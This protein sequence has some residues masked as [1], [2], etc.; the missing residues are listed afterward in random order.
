GAAITSVVDNR[1]PA[2]LGLRGPRVFEFPG[3]TF[4]V[5]PD[6]TKMGAGQMILYRP[7][8]ATVGKTLRRW[9]QTADEVVLAD[10]PLTYIKMDLSGS[11]E[12]DESP[13]GND[14]D[15]GGLATPI[16]G[17]TPAINDGG[18]SRLFNGRLFR[19]VNPLGDL[20][21]S[22]LTLECW[23][24][25]AG[26]AG[27]NTLMDIVD[28]TALQEF[29]VRF[30]SGTLK[31]ATLDVLIGGTTY[32]SG[33]VIKSTFQQAGWMLLHVTWVAAGDI[34]LYANGKLLATI[35]AAAG[36]G[37]SAITADDIIIGL[38]NIGS[39]DELF[40]RIDN[41][42]V[43]T[44]ELNQNAIND[45]LRFGGMVDT[46]WEVVT[47]IETDA[48]VHMTLSAD[49][50]VAT[51]ALT[52]VDLEVIRGQSGGAE[53]DLGPRS[54]STTGDL[55]AD[56]FNNRVVIQKAARYLVEGQVAPDNVSAPTN[57][58]VLSLIRL[59]GTFDLNRGT[60]P[61]TTGTP[62]TTAPLRW[63]GMLD[64]GDFIELFVQS[65]DN[66]YQVLADTAA[67]IFTHLR[68][69]KL[70]DFDIG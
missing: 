68:V 35:S 64:V 30:S 54:K 5:L 39:A 36:G 28:S 47:D 2:G 24:N 62:D 27:P 61:G 16:G 13:N 34:K 45:R 20:S 60:T 21:I 9:A 67:G 40:G 7:P 29:R 3:P 19:L 12:P 15:D 17:G 57:A 63:T 26:D 23:L 58:T 66:A 32:N 49:Q 48:T 55:F 4:S 46:R 70:R 51:T 53:G 37:A 69:T 59:N 31:S 43:Y 8:G 44:T 65:A 33:V 1:P 10:S 25:F 6:I 22:A 41:F 11:T 14:F 18:T 38:N 42:A 50:S 56:I 52:K